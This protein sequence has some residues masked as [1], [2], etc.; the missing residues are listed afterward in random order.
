MHPILRSVFPYAALAVVVGALVWAVSFGTLPPADFSFNN[1]DEIRTIDPARATGSPEGRIIDGVFEGLLRN[2][3]LDQEPDANGIVPL[4]PQPGVAE[5]LPDISDDGRVYTFHIRPDARWSNGRPITSDDFLWSWQRMLHPETGS[6]YAYQLYYVVGA[7]RYNEGTVEVGDKV[8]VE[9]Y[10]R[11]DPNQLFPRGTMLRGILREIL[12]PHEPMI[13]AGTSDKEKSRIEALWK[14]QHV[15]VVEVKPE[16]NGVVDWDAPGERRAF[17]SEEKPDRTLFTGEIE[18]CHHVLDDFHELVGLRAPDD[19]TLIITLNNRT[20]YF[21]ELMAFYPLFPVNRECVE[22]YGSPIW[23]KP[24][25][26]VSN[27]PFLLKMRR[28]RDRIRMAK[29]PNYWNVDNVQLEVVDALPIK[30]ETTSLNMYLK[31]QIEWTTTVPTSIMPELKDRPD[32]VTAPMLTT[33]FY[34]LNTT[35]PPLN[36]PLVRQALNLATNKQEICEHVLKAGQQPARSFVPPGLTGF[37]SAECGE[38]DVDKARELLRQAGYPEGRDIPKLEILFNDQGAHKDIAQVIQRQWK[39][40]LG[41]DVELRNLEWG[42]FLDS[43]QKKDYTVARSGWIGDYPD[44]NT[45]LDMWVTDG[46]NNQT[47][48]SNAKYDA[49]IADAAAESDPQQRMKMLHDAERILMDEVPIIPIYFYVSINMVSPR[50]HG[51][52]PNIQDVHPLSVIRVEK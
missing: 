51:F 16:S 38:Y 30:S 12:A 15:Y 33:Y 25:N 41:I 40:N 22:K 11:R 9:L 28:I 29:N 1:G 10:D 21:N 6:E 19:Q 34:R 44:P 24:Q 7:R 8:E 31:G 43:L 36:N 2:L 5:A 49:L 3:P 47:G 52:A 42:V 23:T 32:F 48:W 26:I 46:A 35:R 17:C 27:G 39:N 13:A 45:F 4:S 20:P 50:V 14:R 18:R 37:E